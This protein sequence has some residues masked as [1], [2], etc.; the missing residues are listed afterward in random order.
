MSRSKRTISE[1]SKYY[2][3]VGTVVSSI[4]IPAIVG[5]AWSVL[6]KLDF[7]LFSSEYWVLAMCLIAS[8]LTAY[9][10]PEPEG[11]EDAGRLRL[12]FPEM[13][14]GFFNTFVLFLTVVGANCW[15]NR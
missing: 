7:S 5:C 10:I 9:L 3:S 4:A 14:W 6:K 11:Y 1:Q 12:T 8:Y 15:L 2:F 13:I